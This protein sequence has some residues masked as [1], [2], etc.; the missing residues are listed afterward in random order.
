MERAGGVD[1]VAKA[2]MV[3][4]IVNPSCLPTEVRA[5][6]ARIQ[7]IEAEL[8]VVEGKLH[9]LSGHESSSTYINLETQRGSLS[10]QI[11]RY[12]DAI[13]QRHLGLATAVVEGA[14]KGSESDRA[15]L[16]NCR[17]YH[18]KSFAPSF[19]SEIA[20]AEF[21]RVLLS[22]LSAAFTPPP[23]PATKEE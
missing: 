20:A 7:A 2:L 11:D 16:E 23:P 1:L 13:A 8:A 12:M 21:G 9:R 19:P 5:G 10:G 18:P 22:E 3:A 6:H 14:M 17:A 4:E 15:I